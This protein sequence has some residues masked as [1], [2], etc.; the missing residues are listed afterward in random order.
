MAEELFRN[1]NIGFYKDPSMIGGELRAKEDGAEGVAYFTLYDHGYAYMPYVF[2]KN[3]YAYLTGYYY[4]DYQSQ[5]MFCQATSGIY[6]VV[7]LSDPKW[8]AAQGANKKIASYTQ[9]QA[10][11]LVQKIINANIRI[12]EN[13]LICARY[14]DK[15]TA[16]EKKQIKELQRRVIER[17]DML[18][19]DGLLKDVQNGYGYTDEQYAQFTPYLDRLMADGSIGV[20]QWVVIVVIALVAASLGTAVYYAYKYYADQAEQDVKFSQELTRTLQTKLTD[21]EYQQLL[22]E[23]KGIVTKA[24]MSQTFKT[25]APIL[26][27]VGVG[28]G[29]LY[30]LKKLNIINL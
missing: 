17:S 23:T 4:L 25:A 28:V 21:E 15:F 6:L 8:V 27:Y 14:A 12:T 29:V 11:A 7:N 26:L 24:R 9:S 16:E 10:Q 22:N 20:S 5:T 2:A 1:S 19:N 13:N 3:D 30:L 18:K